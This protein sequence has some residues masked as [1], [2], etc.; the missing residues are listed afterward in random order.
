L[1]LLD[2]QMAFW[3][4]LGRKQLAAISVNVAAGDFKGK[5][6]FIVRSEGAPFFFDIKELM[7][8]TEQ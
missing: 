3:L 8:S 6:G 1:N 5:R 7:G 4:S 2:Q